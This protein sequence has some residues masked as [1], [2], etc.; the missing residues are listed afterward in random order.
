[1]KKTLLD[2]MEETDA[3]VTGIIENRKE[4]AKGPVDFL[5]K[6]KFQKVVIVSCGSSY[7]IASNIVYYMR[8]RWKMQVEVVSA[9]QFY[10]YD[11]PFVSQDTLFIC[12]SQGGRSTN[13][14]TAARALQDKGYK[15]MG[16]TEDLQSPLG[17]SLKH[18]Y[19]YHRTGDDDYVIK[20][21]VLHSVYMML[22]VS[23]YALTMKWM[24]EEQYNQDISNILK[25]V[26]KVDEVRNAA[27]QFYAGNQKLLQ[28]MTRVIALGC[29]PSL[30]TAQEGCLKMQETYEC[31][32]T[33]FEIEEYF[34]GP[35]LCCSKDTTIFIIDDKHSPVHYRSKDAYHGLH[36]LTDRIIVITND[37]NFEGENI[38]HITDDQIPE[39]IAVLYNII[40]FQYFVYILMDETQV[41]AIGRAGKNCDKFYVIKEQG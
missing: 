30:A 35:S 10:H 19:T 5:K 15:V 11:L 31:Q 24:D 29:G 32:A 2:F 16:M 17:K 20:S 34:H 7:N 8:A 25:A 38:I 3:E 1:M 22:M 23:E 6:Q 13:V 37:E 21:F 39:D 26:H 40:P 28:E 18:A 4:L 27:I 36:C 41:S 14:T 12:M 9:F 33:A